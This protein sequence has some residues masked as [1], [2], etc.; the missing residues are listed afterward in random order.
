MMIKEGDKY[1]DVNHKSVVTELF[2]DFKFK[3]GSS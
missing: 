3:F 2:P 1:I